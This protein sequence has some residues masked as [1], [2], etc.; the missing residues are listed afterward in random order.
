MHRSGL[1]NSQKLLIPQHTF[2]G[3][4]ISLEPRLIPR[5]P[6][7]RRLHRTLATPPPD[8]TPSLVSLPAMVLCAFIQLTTVLS[9]QVRKL[10][11]RNF[12]QALSKRPESHILLHAVART[13]SLCP[14]DIAKIG[15]VLF[16]FGVVYD[17]LLTQPA[18]FQEWFLYGMIAAG[19][20]IAVK[21][22]VEGWF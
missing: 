7:T 4:K 18:W 12:V 22:V 13:A 1:L 16:A 10:S 2:S 15:L 3:F 9:V 17:F 19:T 20:G 21:W 11:S 14:R 8:T 5:L 6:Q